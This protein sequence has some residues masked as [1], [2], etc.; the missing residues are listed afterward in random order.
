MSKGLGQDQAGSTGS[1]NYLEDKYGRVSIE[2]REEIKDSK[3]MYYK[4]ISS[5]IGLMA[6]L[7]AHFL[8]ILD[9]M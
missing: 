7:E 5:S 8:G 3:N 6:E 2:G 4:K 1:H 9:A